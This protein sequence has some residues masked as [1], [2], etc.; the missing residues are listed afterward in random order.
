MI[1]KLPPLNALRAFEAAARR[2]SIKDA[3]EELSVTPGA[4]SQMIRA[5]EL[6]LGIRLFHRSHRAI[7]LTEAGRDYLPA[8][9]NAFRQ[10]SEA[11]RRLAAAAE[12]GLLTVSVTPSFAAAWLAPRLLSFQEGHPDIDL[13]IVSSKALA[14][15]D[16]D[17]VDVAIRHGLGRYPGLHS[18]RLFAVELVPVAA[19]ALVDQ[20]GLPKHPGD[21]T[22]WPHIHD[23]ERKDWH[24]WLQAQG[25]TE[26]GPPRGPAFDDPSLLLTAVLAGQG[27]ALAPA[28]IAALDLAKGR[29]IKLFDIAWPDDFAYYLVYPEGAD[30]RPKVAAFRDWIISAAAEP[31]RAAAQPAI[32]AL[33]P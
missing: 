21:L 17:G 23:A 22:A 18:E 9:L 1:D 5:L 11:T 29:L 16:R 20:L 24:L 30:Q 6:R 4:V 14:N 13:Q 8:I 26:I 19:P 10:I 33:D 15:F 27:A 12:S 25:V 7:A 2:L 28:A 31:A 3:A 32:P